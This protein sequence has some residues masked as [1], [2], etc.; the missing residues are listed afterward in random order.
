MSS[1]AGSWRS[2]TSARCTGRS[3]RRFW[4][5]TSWSARNPRDP[6]LS[7]REGATV[8]ELQEETILVTG[9]TD[10]LGRRVAREL[11]ERGATVLLHGRSRERLEAT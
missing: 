8:R 5:R 2:P 1:A 11:A 10:G 4:W 6:Y 3:T 9:A 7:A